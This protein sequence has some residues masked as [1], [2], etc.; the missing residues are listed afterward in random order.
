MSFKE[1]ILELREEGKSYREIVTMLG[2]SRATVSYHCKRYDLSYFGVKTKKL[3]PDV[4]LK[5]KKLKKEGLSVTKIAEK[6][7]ISEGSVRKYTSKRSDNV[8]EK[9][10]D[11]RQRRKEKA[12]EYKGG[13]CIACGYNKCIRALNFHHLDPN[14]KDFGISSGNTRSWE[15]TKIELDKCILVCSNCHAEIHEGLIT[16]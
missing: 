9:V 2:C 13:K 3:D 5:V 15:K 16:I 12:I 14:E 10:K 6:L 11:F 8:N 1:K 7:E 4:I